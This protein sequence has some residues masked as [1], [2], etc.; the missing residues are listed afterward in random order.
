MSS[1][2]PSAPGAPQGGGEEKALPAPLNIAPFDI[3][4]SPFASTRGSVENSIREGCGDGTLCVSI[5]TRIDPSFTRKPDSTIRDCEVV[6]IDQN[7]PIRRGDTVT[8]TLAEPCTD[9]G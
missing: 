6:D 7:T 3:V 8:F 5:S 9:P 4:G 1:N 2:P